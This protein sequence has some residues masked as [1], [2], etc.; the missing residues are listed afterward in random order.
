MADQ[1]KRQLPLVE[2]VLQPMVSTHNRFVRAQ[3]VVAALERF[4]DV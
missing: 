3:K 2:Q 1:T 4:Y